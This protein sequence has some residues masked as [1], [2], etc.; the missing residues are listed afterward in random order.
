MACLCK[1]HN[2]VT[3]LFR[4]GRGGGG[5]WGGGQAIDWRDVVYFSSLLR[6]LLEN[7]SLQ[8]CELR[9]HFVYLR[10]QSGRN[11]IFHLLPVEIHRI[12]P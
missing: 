4:A 9:R 12:Y 3:N 11:A 7:P 8:T 2:S 10:S 1:Y 6:S 5:G